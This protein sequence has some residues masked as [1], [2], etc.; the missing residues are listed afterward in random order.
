ML[1]FGITNLDQ[2][3]NR[4]FKTFLKRKR[5]NISI[6]LYDK[7]HTFSDADTI[8]ER[9]LLL[10]SDERGAYKRTYQKRFGEF[11]AQVIHELSKFSPPQ[12]FHDVGISDGR[13]ALDF[14]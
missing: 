13:T 6:T 9:I 11:D 7:I 2:M 3:R 5:G 10:F 8:A 14:F 1:K 4:K 12:T